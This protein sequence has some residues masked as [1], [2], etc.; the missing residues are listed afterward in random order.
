ME[1]FS[2]SLDLF[3]K[4]SNQVIIL[5]GYFNV[6]DIDRENSLV[7]P[8]LLTRG[9][10]MAVSCLDDHVLAQYN[11]ILDVCITN[12]SGVIKSSRSVSGISDHCAVPAEDELLAQCIS[13]DSDS[14]S[15]IWSKRVS[16]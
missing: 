13:S 9:S 2:R 7:C 3:P 8:Q 6:P 16:T 10:A 1:E 11:N 12:K 15:F 14:D 5:G 4:N